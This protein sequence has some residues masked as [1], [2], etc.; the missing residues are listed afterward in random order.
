LF[1]FL[2]KYQQ[3]QPQAKVTSLL[4]DSEAVRCLARA[5]VSLAST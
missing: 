2:S 3:N 4:D 1:R 5:T